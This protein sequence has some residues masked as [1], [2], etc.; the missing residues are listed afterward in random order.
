MST[1]KKKLNDSTEV[2]MKTKV[3]GYTVSLPSGNLITYEHDNDEFDPDF[4]QS[5]L[6]ENYIAYNS[7]E[8]CD[9][10]IATAINASEEDFQAAVRDL[11]ELRKIHH[12]FNLDKGI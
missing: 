7:L 5:G 2:T 1:R 12:N 9:E 4:S 6:E 10:F 3:T 11:T 8:I